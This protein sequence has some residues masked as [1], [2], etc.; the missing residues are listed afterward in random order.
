MTTFSGD[1]ENEHLTV[2]TA[3]MFN[4]CNINLLGHQL[5]VESLTQNSRN[6]VSLCIMV[7]SPNHF[8]CFWCFFFNCTNF[9]YFSQFARARISETKT[10]LW[11]REK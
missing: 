8:Y 5:H 9:H 11:V 6:G 3:I 1:R 4:I 7:L 2:L 10:T